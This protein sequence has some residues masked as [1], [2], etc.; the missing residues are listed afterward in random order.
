MRIP[1]SV[2]RVTVFH[3]GGRGADFEKAEK[4]RWREQSLLA[5]GGAS[6]IRFT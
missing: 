2:S 5:F 6:G 3:R 4:I 1:D